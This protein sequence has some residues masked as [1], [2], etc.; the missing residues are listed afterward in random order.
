[1]AKLFIFAAGGSFA[2]RDLR[3]YALEGVDEVFVR[4]F[5]DEAFLASS[6]AQGN[7]RV[8]LW[9]MPVTPRARGLSSRLEPGDSGIGYAQGMFR[10]VTEVRGRFRSPE[11]A[12]QLFGPQQA[13][14]RSLFILLQRSESI[15]LGRRRF[16]RALGYEP[17]FVPRAVMIPAHDK[18]AFITARYGDPRNFLKRA[19]IEGPKALPRIS[20]PPRATPG[21]SRGA[22]PRHGRGED[23]VESDRGPDLT[24]PSGE[25]GGEIGGYALLRC[26]SHA[27][28]R[29]PFAIRVGLAPEP[30]TEAAARI[31]PPRHITGSYALDVE[32]MADGFASEGP[33]WRVR[34]PVARTQP[35]PV[36]DIHVTP[37][38]QR[39][40]TRDA[41][42]HAMYSIGGA[43]VGAAARVV[44]V[45]RDRSVDPGPPPPPQFPDI[46][47]PAFGPD[48]IPDLTV[49]IV[50]SDR[51]P[52]HLVWSFES[53]HADVEL[54]AGPF[55]TDVGS[56]PREFG[57]FVL[58]GVPRHEGKT[59]LFRF[60][61]GVGRQIADAMP[62][63]FWALLDAVR[64]RKQRNDDVTLLILSAEPHVPWELALVPKAWRTCDSPFLAAEASVGRWVLR[65]HSQ[66]ISPPVHT[67]GRPFS[68]IAGRYPGAARLKG[69][70]AEAAELA[71]RFNGQRVAAS[72][73]AV[74]PHLEAADAQ[75]F[76]F[77]VHGVSRARS[78]R[79]GLYLID[80]EYL[81][82]TTVFG[83]EF[84]N[85][86][87]VFL[88]ACEVATGQEVLGAYAGL[89]AAFVSVGAAA[90]IAPLW[91]IDDASAGDLALELYDRC[92]SGETPADVLREAR[93]TF[94]PGARSATFIAYQLFGHPLLGLSL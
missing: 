1:V 78:A 39:E 35:Y 65:P 91:E 38:P 8:R 22:I 36:A 26:P 46:S 56:S 37:A 2:L 33:S 3:T 87:F 17:G 43:T 10:V 13:Q 34:L 67:S 61:C 82:P 6:T 79:D 9:G 71:R 15:E 76:H 31:S 53:A 19:S 57:R 60:L 86:P 54:P 84:E 74:L 24:T 48:G 20:R 83:L 16:S 94:R 75:V 40:P 81:E 45:L 50:L 77:A 14:D 73:S 42:I 80:G 70:E 85:S 63:E 18:Q 25:V 59:D 66:R 49:R 12:T 28:A 55:T 30:T 7:G 92:A 72:L 64:N 88:N 90:V 27:V 29:E 21:R 47:L 41:L 23:R 44:R 32:V 11:L 89:A 69:A 52:G 93:Q 4:P 5:V 51:S 68:V 62:S 58:R